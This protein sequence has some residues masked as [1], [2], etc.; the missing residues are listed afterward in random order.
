MA[1][2]FGKNVQGYIPVFK[3]MGIA[4]YKSAGTPTESGPIKGALVVDTTN[5]KLYMNTGTVASATWNAIGDIAASEITLAEGSV[6]VGNSSGVSVALNGKASGQILVGNGTTLVSVAVSGDATLSSAGA[7]AVTKINGAT[8]GTAT[9]TSG[10]VLIGSGTAWVTNAVSGDATLSSTGAVTIAAAV[11]TRAKQSAPA[12]RKAT[13]VTSATI[14]TTSTTDFYILAE[15]TGSLVSVDFNGVDVLATSDTNYITWSIVNQ[16]QSGAGTTDMLDTGAV[17]TTKV[18]GGSAL[19]ANTKRS[20]SVHGTPAN[21]DCA[22]G[23]LI[24]V[25]ATATGTLANTVTIPRYVLR[26]T[27]TT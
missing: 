22:A 23:D 19:A 4:I 2:E 7:I 14:A 17:N 11:V 18:T 16:G 27:G 9:A 25:R 15:E 3:E 21:L 5:A 26:F 20:L 10:N 12:A 13:H 6:L 1:N 8:M 24:R